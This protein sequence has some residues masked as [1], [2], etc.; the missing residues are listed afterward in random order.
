MLIE[1]CMNK[2]YKSLLISKQHQEIDAGF[3]T[4]K[5]QLSTAP[6]MQCSSQSQKNYFAKRNAFT[7]LPE[8]IEIIYTPSAKS[9]TAISIS[10]ALAILVAYT[11]CPEEV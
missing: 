9:L 6:Q 3:S 1:F 2:N 4:A 7:S 10:P 5:N 11:C 8:R